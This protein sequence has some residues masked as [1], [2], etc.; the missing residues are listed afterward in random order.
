MCF[1]LKTHLY[2]KKF[3]KWPKRPQYTY[4]NNDFQGQVIVKSLPD[5]TELRNKYLFLD[6][7]NKGIKSSSFI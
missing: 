5:G 4:V 3:E 6:K 7:G 2:E 1:A